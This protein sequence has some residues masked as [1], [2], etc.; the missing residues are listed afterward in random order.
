MSQEPEHQP[1][2]A[3]P[4]PSPQKTENVHWSDLG[5]EEVD[6]GRPAFLLTKTELKLL[7]IAGV[8]KFLS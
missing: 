8:R 3:G 5:G 6:D 7:G 2:S 4:D 1:T